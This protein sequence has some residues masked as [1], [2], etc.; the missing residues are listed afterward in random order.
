MLQ[1]TTA[2]TMRSRFLLCLSILV[3]LLGAV[4]SL[5]SVTVS[6]A[7]LGVNSI[8]VR[9]WWDESSARIAVLLFVCSV[10]YRKADRSSGGNADS[11][12][13]CDSPSHIHQNIISSV[14][15]AGLTVLMSQDIIDVSTF[16][17]PDA[18]FMNGYYD[19]QVASASGLSGLRC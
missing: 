13:P 2:T 17:N 6:P 4:S 19:T 16:S 5:D 12:Q 7:K 15:Y 18:I 11:L 14:F 10:K 8:R 1:P 3:V 9:G